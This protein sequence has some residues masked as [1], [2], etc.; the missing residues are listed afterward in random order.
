MRVEKW[1]LPM[2]GLLGALAAAIVV[3]L[4]IGG[5]VESSDSA[6]REDAGEDSGDAIEPALEPGTG[7]GA[8]GI[9]IE[10]TVDCVDTPTNPGGDVGDCPD[11][12][13]PCNDVGAGIDPDE[14][15]SSD[16][17]AGEPVV[18]E[19]DAAEPP[20]SGDLVAPDECSAVH[21]PDACDAEVRKLALADLAARLGVEAEAITFVDSQF[22]EWPDACLGAAA[23][24]TACATVITPGYVIILAHNNVEYEYHTDTGSNVVLVVDGEPAE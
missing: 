3:L 21:N 7:G 9:C 12:A 15:V 11:G 16:P 17:G 14:P 22:V 23:P 18:S 5:T 13:T 4:A 1:M 8:A 2:G 20:N 10:G 19:P 24:G 6:V